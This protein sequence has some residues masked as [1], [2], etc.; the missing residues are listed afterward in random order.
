VYGL[1]W[2]GGLYVNYALLAAWVADV[3][4]WWGRGLDAYRRRPW[5]LAAA[6]HAF[7]VFI[8]FNATVVFE[9]GPVRW[10]GLGVCLGLCFAWLRAAGKFSPRGSNGRALAAAKD[11]TT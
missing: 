4:W 7:L 6:W 8:V 5:P 11:S 3:V 9:G 2:G 1:G 10:A